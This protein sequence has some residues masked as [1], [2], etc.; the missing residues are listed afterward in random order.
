[1]D[2]FKSELIRLI[3]ERILES[4]WS[5][6]SMQQFEIDGFAY[7]VDYTSTIHTI[8][9]LPSMSYDQPDDKDILTVEL[10]TVDIRNV[11]DE[12]GDMLPTEQ[13]KEINDLFYIL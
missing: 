4:G 3:K 13:L 7:D 12:N 10:H 1:M 6:G 2:N 5:L 11:W 9:G 8:Y